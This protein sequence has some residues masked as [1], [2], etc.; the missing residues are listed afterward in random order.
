M[1]HPRVLIADD[2]PVMLLVLRQSL[3]RAGYAVEEASSGTE[4]VDMAA[5]HAYDAIVLD[6]RMPGLDGFEATHAIR[7]EL[8][9][10]DVPIILMSAK[11]DNAALDEGLDA[12]ADD[13]LQKPFLAH[14]ITER[15]E[16]LRD[17]SADATEA[18]DV[19]AREFHAALTGEGGRY[20]AGTLE[21]HDNPVHAADTAER[22]APYEPRHVDAAG[23]HTSEAEA[24]GAV[25]ATGL[26]IDLD[27]NGEVTAASGAAVAALHLP[28]FPKGLTPGVLLGKGYDLVPS[29]S[30]A[31]FAVDMHNGFF[32]VLTPHEGLAPTHRAYEVT[33]HQ[34]VTGCRVVLTDVTDSLLARAGGKIPP[35]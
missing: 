24:D 35:T 4:A 2:N 13:F 26:W 30:W 20:P 33:A 17:H 25:P 32:R 21:V 27:V 12:G 19:D 28:S 6:V 16:E 23:S 8:P 3:Q 11:R 7:E 10:H 5:H 34:T 22:L 31:E 29:M 9:G 14:D 18:A 15:I 1:R